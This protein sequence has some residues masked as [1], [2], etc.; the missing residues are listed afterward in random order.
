MAVV[1]RFPTKEYAFLKRDRSATIHFANTGI[2]NEIQFA[3]FSRW[4][5]SVA[6]LE[7]VA[8]AGLE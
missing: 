5:S 8:S 4:H 6:V 1:L 2:E 3:Q 7:E